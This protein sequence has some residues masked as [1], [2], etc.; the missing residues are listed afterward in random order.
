LVSDLITQAFLDMG[1]TVP[2]ETPNGSEQAD[3]LLRLNQLL[4]TWSLE[5]LTVPNKAHG[6]FT[7]VAGTKDYTFGVGGTLAVA[8]LTRPICITGAASISGAFRQPVE[9]M[10]F[11]KFAAETS[12]S[13]GSTSVLALKLAV[14]ASAPLINIR[15]FP[16]PA[17]APGLL[18][19]DYWLVLAGFGA[20]SDDAS[21]LTL[22]MQNALHWNLAVALYPQYPRAGGMPPELAANAQNSKGSIVELQRSLQGPTPPAAGA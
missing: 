13:L 2:G 17:T 1:A 12:D 3:A 14:D 7:A 6:S 19:L 22:E 10:G 4:G 18:W 15:I 5:R 20:V 16:T 11:D 8:P 9:V 21:G